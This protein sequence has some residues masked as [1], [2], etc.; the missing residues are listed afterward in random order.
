M[1]RPQRTPPCRGRLGSD[2]ASRCRIGANFFAQA[3]SRGRQISALWEGRGELAS[4]TGSGRLRWKT[5]EGI[6]TGGG[7]ILTR[8]ILAVAGVILVAVADATTVRRRVMAARVLP[9]RLRRDR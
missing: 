8:V 5:V 4:G 1:R 7:A 9:S 2:T 3:R 6:A